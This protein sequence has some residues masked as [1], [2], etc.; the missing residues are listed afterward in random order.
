MKKQLL[1]LLI[2]A[3]ALVSAWADKTTVHSIH[4]S[5]P[6]EHQNWTDEGYSDNPDFWGIDANW[7]MMSVRDSGFS[8]IIGLGAGATKVD[9]NNDFYGDV[10]PSGADFNFKLGIGYAP[11]HKED[12]IFALHGFW[13]L[14][15][16]LLTASASYY[17]VDTYCES[18]F[19]MLDTV[20]VLGIDGVFAMKLSDSFGIMAGLDISTNLFGI[21]FYDSDLHDSDDD[22]TGNFWDSAYRSGKSMSLPESVSAGFLTKRADYTLNSK[23]V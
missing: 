18:D 23:S 15:M 6:I 5:V 3:C 4:L 10:D 9:W 22:G 21:V 20:N 17:D 8:F 11:I 2:A 14:D 19:L 1:L 7:N 16:K 13:A 12:M